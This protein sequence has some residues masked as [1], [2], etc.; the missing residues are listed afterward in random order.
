MLKFT[1]SDLNRRPGEVVEA[2]LA[3]P[4]CLTRHG[5]D[6]LVIIH[7]NR[8]EELLGTDMKQQ[9]DRSRPAAGAGL[10]HLNDLKPQQEDWQGE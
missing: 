5:R 7:M 10:A 3:G 9:T 8:Y 4:V 6:K 1:L 2:A